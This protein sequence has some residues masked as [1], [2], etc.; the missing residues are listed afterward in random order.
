V[1][2]GVL[3]SLAIPRFTEASAKAKMGE[4]PRQIASFESGYLAAVAELGKVGSQKDMVIKI[5]TL[6]KWFAYDADFAVDSSGVTLTVT[7]NSDIGKFL[8]TNSL[9]TE[10]V[11][12]NEEDDGAGFCRSSDATLTVLEKLVPSFAATIKTTCPSSST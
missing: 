1:I 6:S 2:I 7:A 5:D 9:V 4:A 11:P 3:A 10:Y 12:D 8:T